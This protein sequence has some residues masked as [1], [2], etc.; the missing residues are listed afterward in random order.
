MFLKGYFVK[1]DRLL[2]HTRCLSVVKIFAVSVATILRRAYH[3]RILILRSA[4]TISCRSHF[5][6]RSHSRNQRRTVSSVPL[7]HYVALAVRNLITEKKCAFFPK[8]SPWSPRGSPN[9]SI[10]C[11]IIH[12]SLPLSRFAPRIRPRTIWF[13][14]RAPAAANRID[15][16]GQLVG[17]KTG[18]GGPRENETSA[19]RHERGR[20]FG[21]RE[22]VRA[23][24]TSAATLR[25]AAEGPGASAGL[26]DAAGCCTLLGYGASHHAA[27]RIFTAGLQKGLSRWALRAHLEQKRLYREGR[28]LLWT[29][30]KRFRRED[31]SQYK[32]A[33]SRREITVNLN[34]YGIHRIFVS[35]QSVTSPMIFSKN[36]SFFLFVSMIAYAPMSFF[37]SIFI[38]R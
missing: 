25:E 24:R 17:N 36:Y 26:R 2:I 34:L 3:S 27:R 5:I 29:E 30:I 15:P 12:P 35:W 32:S 7:W 33:R 9:R 19:G 21:D 6:S 16:E 20:L 23:G 14:C 13:A 28:Y 1:N 31:I 10:D 8:L 37:F 4:A 11:S 18:V 38:F 22:D